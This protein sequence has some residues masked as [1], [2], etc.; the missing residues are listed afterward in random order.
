[1]PFPKLHGCDAY[2]SC[3]PRAKAKSSPGLG[4]DA[5]P[6]NRDL[7]RHYGSE[8]GRCRNNRHP[9]VPSPRLSLPANLSRSHRPSDPSTLSK[10]RATDITSSMRPGP[11]RASPASGRT[12]QAA[13]CLPR[14][15]LGSA[16]QD[17]PA[18]VI[19]KVECSPKSAKCTPRLPPN[20]FRL[21]SVG[22]SRACRK[23]MARGENLAKSLYW[24]DIIWSGRRDS[25]PRPQPWQNCTHPTPGY[26]HLR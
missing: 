24:G 12:A 3:C 19:T 5:P 8:K 22:R 23:R 2:L 11:G 9:A 18:A 25:N 16:A 6:T 4:G 15:R 1:M 13:S 14:H 7:Q 20:C 26:S 17:D 21:A 10:R